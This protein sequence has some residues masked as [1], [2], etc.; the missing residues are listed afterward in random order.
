MPPKGAKEIVFK[1]ESQDMFREIISET[2]KK[3][4]GKET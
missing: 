2:N 1:V 4:T 3:V